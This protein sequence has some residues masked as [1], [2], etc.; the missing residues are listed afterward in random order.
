MHGK[1]TNPYFIS[2]DKF[3]QDLRERNAP[4]AEKV[5]EEHI[6]ALIRDVGNYGAEY[7]RQKA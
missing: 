3:L 6:N 2:R 7:G 1:I 4:K 5:L